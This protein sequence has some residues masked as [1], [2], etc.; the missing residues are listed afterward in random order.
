MDSS[1]HIFFDADV[2]R[3]LD[4]GAVY[5]LPRANPDGA[6]LAPYKWAV[7]VPKLRPGLPVRGGLARSAFFL[8]LIKSIALKSWA[9]L[10]DR[11][12]VPQASATCGPGVD[13][14]SRAVARRAL[15]MFGRGWSPLVPAGIEFKVLES[16]AAGKLSEKLFAEALVY[17]D[18]QMSK[19]VLGQTM[20]ADDGSSHSQATVHNQVRKDIREQDAEDLA[21]TLTRD[22]V[23][24]FVDVN[25][26]VQD[27]YPSV[28]FHLAEPTDIVKMAQALVP[29]LDRVPI[30]REQ[31][32]ELLGLDVPQEGDDV[33][34][35]ERSR[36]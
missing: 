5:I 11:Y 3:N 18:K 1:L 8:H 25:F 13:D 22:V 26:G 30:K 7:H 19:L 21:E 27:V 28:F 34:G 12:G 2:E 23:R 9:R 4:T 35:G 15:E 29:V 36:N 24:A 10:L 16:A 31:F 32:Y 14:R 17:C 20:T 6:A 33:V